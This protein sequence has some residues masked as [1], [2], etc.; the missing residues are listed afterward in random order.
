[1]DDG[2]HGEAPAVEKVEGPVGGPQAELALLA[3][4][5]RRR[6]Q[7]GRVKGGG[8]RGLHVKYTS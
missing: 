6:E 5:I 3:L 7:G 8:D 2:V 4:E 1:M